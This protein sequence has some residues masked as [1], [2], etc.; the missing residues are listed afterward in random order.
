VQVIW[1]PTDMH[2]WDA[3]DIHQWAADVAADP[4]VTPYEL[5][6]A[7]TA[8]AGALA[9]IQPKQPKQSRRRPRG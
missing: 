5:R 3:D 2:T 1:I 8:A 4:E 9:G 6:C 7:R